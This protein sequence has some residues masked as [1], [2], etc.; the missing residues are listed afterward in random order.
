MFQQ[1]MNQASAAIDY[2]SSDE[3]KVLL[4]DDEKLEEQVNE[5]VNIYQNES[6]PI[7]RLNVSQFCV[8]FCICIDK[9]VRGR[10]GSDNQRKSNT[11]RRKC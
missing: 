9:E 4:N 3:L 1:Y 8:C 7:I 10:E 5:V 2:L 6:F 11:G